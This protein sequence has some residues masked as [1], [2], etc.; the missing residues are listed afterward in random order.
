MDLV[1]TTRLKI[2]DKQVHALGLHWETAT[3]NEARAS[4]ATA[5]IRVAVTLNTLKEMRVNRVE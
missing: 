5:L 2:K 1:P 4:N 3:Q